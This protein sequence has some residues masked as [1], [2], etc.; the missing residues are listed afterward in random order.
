LF[1]EHPPSFAFLE[2]KTIMERW[3]KKSCHAL[4]DCSNRAAPGQLL[5]IIVTINVKVNSQDDTF[6]AIVVV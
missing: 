5:I 6:S 1:L 4:A 2:K 3:S